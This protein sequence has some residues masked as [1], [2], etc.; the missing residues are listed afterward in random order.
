MNRRSF[1]TAC[2]ATMTPP[3]IVRAASLMPVSARR[4]LFGRDF[5]SQDGMIVWDFETGEPAYIAGNQ[6]AFLPTTY[7]TV[8]LNA[9][10]LASLPGLHV[11]LA[12]PATYRIKV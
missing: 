2:I 10:W 1:L 8:N 4:G 11:D 6:W 9:N 3:A 7:E 5:G 12:A